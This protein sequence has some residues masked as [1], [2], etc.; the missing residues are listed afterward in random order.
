VTGPRHRHGTDGASHRQDDPPAMTE[1]TDESGDW[2][3]RR[4][5]T[6]VVGAGHT[7]AD[8][9]SRAQ[10]TQAFRRILDGEPAPRTHGAF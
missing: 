10:A 6:E 3:L 2:P 1:A 4:L 7:S 9:V 5:L 8:D